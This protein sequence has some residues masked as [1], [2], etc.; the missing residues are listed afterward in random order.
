MPTA[1]I[2]GAGIAGPV[3]AMALRRAGIDV[4][5]HEAYPAPAAEAGSWIGL[6][7]NGLDALRAIGADRT[8]RRLAVPTPSIAFRT[9][10]GRPLGEIPTGRPLPGGTA[11]VSIKRSDLHRALRDEA[12]RRGVEI[13]HGQRLVSVA[14]GADGVVA[15]FADGSTAV[16]DLLVGCDGIHSRVRESLNPSGPRAR[17]V[18][19]LNVGGYADVTPPGDRPGVLTMTFGRRA[20]SGRL[21]T[22]TGQ[23]WW[24]ANPP[25]RDEPA[26]GELREI[27]DAQWRDSLRQLYEPDRS[28]I[29]DLIGATPGPLTG[30]A[31]YD[32]PTVPVWHDDRAVLIGDAAHATSPSSGQG[33]SMAI[34]DAVVLGQCLRD[35]PVPRAFARFEA[36]RRPRVERVVAEGRKSSRLRSVGPVG[37]LARGLVLPLVL[38]HA[39]GSGAESLAWIHQHHID[40][41]T[42]VTTTG[43][44]APTPAK[45]IPTNLPG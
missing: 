1:L 26:N 31:T 12:S 3:A 16:G 6:Q 45:D 8:V 14:S 2:I 33:A 37:R 11:G 42:P 7:T 30:W 43:V 22:P 5:V 35:L 32:L 24:F 39:A 36:L 34:E 15:T 21:V 13:R 27:S 10:T 17:Y 44:P 38:R 18:P 4:L 25:R 9:G 28:P 40:W 29:M 23:T 20:F 41:D 19:I